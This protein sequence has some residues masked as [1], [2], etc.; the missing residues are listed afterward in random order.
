MSHAEI[1]THQFTDEIFKNDLNRFFQEPILPRSATLTPL[2]WWAKNGDRF[3]TLS[4][5]AKT[6][7]CVPASSAPS[8]RVFSVAGLTVNKLRSSLLSENVNM[9][10]TLHSNADLL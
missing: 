5:V 2:Q 7:L 1:G 10:V 8:E 9:L 4:A 3:P 6:Y